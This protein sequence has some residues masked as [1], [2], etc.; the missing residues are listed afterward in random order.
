MAVG[1]GRTSF[2]RDGRLHHKLKLAAVN[3]R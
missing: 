1:V 3:A 2:E